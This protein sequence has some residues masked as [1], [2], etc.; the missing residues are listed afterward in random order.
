MTTMQMDVALDVP[1]DKLV[2][3]QKQAKKALR[4]SS[5]AGK[6][7][8][9][10]PSSK[11][12]AGS[13]GSGKS[14]FTRSGATAGLRSSDLRATLSSVSLVRRA[15]SAPPGAG[16]K[17]LPASDLR[18]SLSSQSAGLQTASAAA[19]SRASATATM[20]TSS[21]RNQQ[22][23]QQQQQHRPM[24]ITIT[25]DRLY[26]NANAGDKNA[27]P[28]KPKDKTYRDPNLDYVQ[29]QRPPARGQQV[30]TSPP[31]TIS[32]YPVYETPSSTVSQNAFFPPTGTT[33]RISNLHR[34]ASADDLKAVFSRFGD[35]LSVSI[36]LDAQQQSLGIATIT[37]T[38]KHAALMAVQQ[39]HNTL[40][41]GNLLKAELIR[42]PTSATQIV[43]HIGGNTSFVGVGRR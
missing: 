29:I 25:N 17:R 3:E 41:D 11:L 32:T 20:A 16:G 2:T 39:Y 14:L 12:S 19:K 7:P 42:N 15:K 27:K 6:A 4:T 1:L 36:Q 22:Q 38:S 23:Q 10:R 35:I 40:V 37:F 24:T 43:G 33:V 8:R 5:T 13:A 26:S 18:S 34:S 31:A 28:N 9:T 21:P 30:S